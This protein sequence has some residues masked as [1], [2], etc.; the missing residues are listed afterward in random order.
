MVVKGE[1]RDEKRKTSAGIGT[2]GIG[3]RYFCTVPTN[4]NTTDNNK[5]ETQN[6]NDATGGNRRT[7][8]MTQR[9]RRMA[10]ASLMMLSMV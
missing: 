3:T 1:Y 9:R 2:F 4:K 6:V 8:V 5:N 10:A 7:Q